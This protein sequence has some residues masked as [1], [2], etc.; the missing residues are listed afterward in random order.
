M[1]ER[2]EDGDQFN[3]R[4]TIDLPVPAAGGP[5][6]T[7][8]VTLDDWM[9]LLSDDR[10]LNRAYMKRFGVDVGYVTITVK[11]LRDP[12]RRDRSSAPLPT[13]TCCAPFTSI[14]APEI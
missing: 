7:V 12:H 5:A 3:W 6:S 9:W 8:R 14:S 1:A 10:L 11:K 13:H 4:Y 2:R